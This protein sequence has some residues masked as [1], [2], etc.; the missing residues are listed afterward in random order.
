M[1]LVSAT[2]AAPSTL[3]TILGL[4]S[5]IFGSIVANPLMLTLPNLVTNK[6]IEEDVARWLLTTLRVAI[7]ALML[8]ARKSIGKAFN[9]THLLM[10]QAL[11][12]SF[13]CKKILLFYVG[14]EISLLPIS[15]LIIGW[16]Y[17]PERVGALLYMFTYTVRGSLPLLIT[18][19]LLHH[20]IRL[21]IFYELRMWSELGAHKN[22]TQNILTISLFLGFLVKFP[23]YGLHLW[24]PKA[25]VEAPVGGS[26]ILA[27][28]LLKLGGFG[29]IQLLPWAPNCKATIVLASVSLR[30]GLLISIV[31]TRQVD[32][33]VLIAYSSVGHLRVAIMAILLKTTILKIG[34]LVILIA[35]GVRSPGMFYG[36]HLIYVRT[37][38]RSILTNTRILNVLPLLT[39]WWFILSMA[40]IGAPPILNL[41]GELV[42]LRGAA[43]INILFISQLGTLV[44]FGGAYTLVLYAACQQGQKKVN[45]KHFSTLSLQ[46]RLNLLIITLPLGLLSLCL[47]LF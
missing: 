12:L 37:H 20:K 47:H 17:Q 13:I 41:L 36:A 1:S 42:S 15:L 14:F 44:F 46:E 11:V 7:V 18:I 31:C 10:A 34:A 4:C 22:T 29:I 19:Y 24:L 30:G 39:M 28:L 32:I 5:L 21:T 25:H 33:K 38:S 2:A 3:Y 23:V 8:T 35:H 9:W 6:W 40:N 45:T 26:I 43:N 16:G 27:R